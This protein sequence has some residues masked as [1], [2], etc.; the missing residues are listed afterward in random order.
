MIMKSTVSQFEALFS[1]LEKDIL[2]VLWQKNKVTVREIYSLLRK[3]RVL[4][5]SSVAVLLDRLYEQGIVSRTI[6]KGKGG[7][8]YTYFPKKD[9]CEFEK[10]LIEST[11]NKLIRQFGNTATSYFEGRFSSRRAK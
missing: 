4:A 2:A 1:P 6:H 5:L 10:S 3:K 11:V 8:H 9:K 7:I